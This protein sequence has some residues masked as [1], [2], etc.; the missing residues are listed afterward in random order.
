MFR[1]PSTDSGTT[2]SRFRSL[3]PRTA[4]GVMERKGT[5]QKINWRAK[6]AGK[7]FRSNKQGYLHA[8]PFIPDM[9]QSRFQGVVEMDRYYP[10]D[11]VEYLIN[12][13]WRRKSL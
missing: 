10:V 8:T 6:Q 3:G 2:H 1:K 5:W 9:S 11:T 12:P 4:V 7:R 13:H